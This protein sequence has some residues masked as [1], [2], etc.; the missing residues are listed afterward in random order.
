MQT[1][2]KAIYIKVPVDAPEEKSSPPNNQ[3][4]AWGRCFK[5]IR[6]K[7]DAC[8][9]FC[10]A[11]LAAGGVSVVYKLTSIIV[12]DYKDGNDHGSD[13]AYAAFTALVMLPVAVGGIASFIFPCAV[14]IKRG[15]SRT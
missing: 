14:G 11:L 7:S 4:F 13:D 5:T 10:S 12:E 2:K 15:C 3:G 9:Y 6:G 1:D 8:L